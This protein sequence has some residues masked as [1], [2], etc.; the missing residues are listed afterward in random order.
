MPLLKKVSTREQARR[1]AYA[2]AVFLAVKSVW[3]MAC[4]PSGPMDHGDIVERRD[5]LLGRTLSPTFSDDH[6]V[7]P[8]GIFASEWRLVSLSM[9][10]AA[11]ANIA[12]AHPER[13]EGASEACGELLER[14]LHPAIRA[15]EVTAWGTDPLE[16]LSGPSGHIGYLGH[17]GFMLGT[18]RLL[19]GDG[20]HDALYDAI[21]AAI[22]RRM[23]ASS[24]WHLET[25]PGEIYTA[26]NSVGVAALALHH[27][28][29]QT[30]RS[31]AVD[32]WITYTKRHLIDRDNGIIVF[33]VGR[34]GSPRGRGRGS[35]AGYNSFFLP[36]IDPAL[37]S[38]QRARLREHLLVDMPFG[39]VGVREY[40][41][42]VDGRGDVDTGPLLFGVSPSATGF[43]L[44]AARHD[45]DDALATGLLRTA[46][47]A[48][49]S[50]PAP[51]GRCYALAPL[52]GDAIVLAMRTAVP[53]DRRFVDDT[54]LVTAR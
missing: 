1:L 8:A 29:H 27:A 42:G 2:C 46:E 22:A 9:T 18:C 11:V 35:A 10:A 31:E 47:L 33:G 50:V 26:D 52:V 54:T 30:P 16:D 41:S 5:Y 24:S 48:G 7:A 45:G 53:W 38:E 34:D 3:V 17:L 20:R 23:Q 28:I 40:S 13:R 44:A 12:F 39:A 21:V 15:F 49:F 14:A 25:Y 6:M 51:G 43:A 4:A 37:A 19:G 32:G 36:F